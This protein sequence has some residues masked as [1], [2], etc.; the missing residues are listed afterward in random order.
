V[1]G[2]WLPRLLAEAATVPPVTG[3]RARRERA[4]TAA[5]AA[6]MLGYANGDAW[7]ATRR[8][9]ELSAANQF[10][11]LGALVAT[12]AWALLDGVT[13][14]ELGLGRE[15]LGRGLGWGLLVGL[16]GSVPI[17]VFF[18]FPIISQRAVS[19]PEFEGMSW[20]R[21]PWIVSTRFLF[22]SALFEEIAFRGL[23][24]AKL[25]RVLRPGPALLV[26]SGIFAAWHLVITWHNLKRSN[27][28]RRLFPFLYVG[29]LAALFGGGL[30]FGLVRQATG[31]LA[32][33]VLAHWLM[34]AN[35]VFAV[36]RPRGASR[37]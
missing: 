36:A 30:L 23:L 34:V 35:I 11:H 10:A 3:R 26:N 8:E 27:L 29:A 19:Q 18:A 4:S 32:G 15:R 9:Q 6:L 5:L 33:A 24:H 21:V 16:L 12:L 17:R 1:R 7:L 2:D 14:R 28:P 20:G 13:P 25:L 37:R 22:G 31:H